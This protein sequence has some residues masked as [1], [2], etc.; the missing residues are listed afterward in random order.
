MP[1]ILYTTSSNSMPQ[2]LEGNFINI[3]VIRQHLIE[4]LGVS[5]VVLTLGTKFRVP[6]NDNDDLSKY[7]NKPFNLPIL[8]HAELI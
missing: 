4:K 6:L 2:V 3:A 5:N 7:L 1:S 8:I